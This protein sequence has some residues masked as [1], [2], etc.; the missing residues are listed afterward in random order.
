[1]TDNAKIEG[2][3]KGLKDELCAV[4]RGSETEVA[5]ISSAFES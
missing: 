3:V 1:M 5:I 4:G 2:E